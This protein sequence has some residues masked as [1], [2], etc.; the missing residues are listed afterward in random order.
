SVVAA[1][2]LHSKVPLTPAAGTPQL[3]AILP[4]ASLPVKFQG[5]SAATTS[6]LNSGSSKVPFIGALPPA[7]DPVPL[8]SLPSCFRSILP[9]WSGMDPPSIFNMQDQTPVRVFVSPEAAG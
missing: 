5:A 2:L 3:P 7:F 9:G 4:F 1:G 6:S 8:T